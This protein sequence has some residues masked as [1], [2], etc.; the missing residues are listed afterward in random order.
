MFVVCTHSR[1]LFD[2]LVPTHANKRD[3]FI[4]IHDAAGVPRWITVLLRPSQ[5]MFPYV[6][7]HCIVY[8]E[9]QN[10]RASPRVWSSHPA[11][12]E[13]Y[14]HIEQY[15]LP[16]PA[17]VAFS[18]GDEHCQ[19]VYAEVHDVSTLRSIL[20]DLISAT[21]D[22]AAYA[23]SGLVGGGSGRRSA[24]ARIRGGASAAANT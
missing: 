19:H 12:L 7:P 24:R 9:V 13:H 4:A 8:V 21:S 11:G 18:M 6:Q 16:L 20:F 17:F 3:G 14:T 15:K 5:D 10:P 2:A 22:A 1:L 23:P